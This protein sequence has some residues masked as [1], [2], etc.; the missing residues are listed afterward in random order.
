MRNKG[1]IPIVV[2]IVVIVAILLAVNLLNLG[3]AL[4]KAL[5]ALHGGR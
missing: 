5:I 1:I 4:V 3:P 2:A